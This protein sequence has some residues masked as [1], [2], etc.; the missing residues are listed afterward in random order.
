MEA[1]K[2]MRQ[3][4]RV[5][6]LAAIL[7]FG[8]LAGCNKQ[9]AV[10]A[11]QDSGPIPVKVVKVAARQ[12]PRDVESVG[13]LFP[14]EEVTISSE[15]D[16]RVVEVG[17]DL[18]DS[19]PKG[20]VLVRVSD[21]EQRYLLAQNEAQLRQSLERLG[22]K[23]EKDRVA[24]IKL[25]PDVRRAQADLTDAQQ[26]YTRS[27]SLSDQGIGSK[28][29]LDAAETH[30]HAMQAAYDTTLN[31][32][33][34][35]V[36]EIERMKAVVDLQRK[37]LR[38]T[39]IVAPEPGWVKDRL[40]N[41]GQYVRPN[42]PVFTLVKIDPIRLRIEAPERMAPWV[43]TGQVAEVSLEAFP[44]RTFHGKI[45][46]I[47]PTVDQSKRTFIVEAL[48]DNP[49]ALLKPGSYAKARVHTDKLD[50]I[51]LVPTLAINYVFGS[52]KVYVVKGDIIEAREVKIGDRF[53]SDTEVIEGVEAG[54]TIASTQVARLDSGVKVTIVK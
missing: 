44:N 12:A 54:E 22:L 47:S 17:A 2:H 25:T 43:K 29:D 35:L 33:R 3:R 38:D 30:Y 32:T 31:Q 23:D 49:G 20:H 53:G 11:K 15:I 45:W 19:V 8:A 36:R 21:E 34:N 39:T 26:R 18:G 10:Q 16:G 48:I 24:D 5:A 51:K 50:M 9:P 6:S 42:T 40:V 46:R 13:T 28:Q 52:N 7:A 4:G 27:R 37:K 1:T 41:V 14:F